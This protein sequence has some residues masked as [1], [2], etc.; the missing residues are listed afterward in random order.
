MTQQPNTRSQGEIQVLNKLWEYKEFVRRW[1][2]SRSDYQT[3]Q[4]GHHGL[5]CM[6]CEAYYMLQADR[7]GMR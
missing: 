2:E 7:E 6:V 4:W 5:L 1:L 3:H